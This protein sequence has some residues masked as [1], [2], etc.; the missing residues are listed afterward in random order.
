VSAHGTLG[1][2][3]FGAR[4]KLARSLAERGVAGTLKRAALWPARTSRRLSPDHIRRRREGR[5]FDRRHGVDT[6]KGLEAGWI[7]SL[8]GPSWR[9]AYGYDPITPTAFHRALAAI[10]LEP[11]RA[12]FVDF[13]AGKGRAMLLA[14]HYS[15]RRVLGVE[16]APG[17]HRVAAENLARYRP[18]ERVCQ[19]AEVV[20]G[21]ALAF[22]IP[23]DPAV[24]YFYDPFG[25]AVF[26]P[27][28]ERIRRSLL[29]RPRTAWIVYHDPR[30]GD[31]VERAGFRRVAG[32][33]GTVVYAWETGGA[34]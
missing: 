7:V 1:G 5:A 30:C 10:P 17:L 24:F 18:P 26:A 29:A 34:S 4:R 23:D 22:T 31:L 16:M 2:L 25:P 20:R 3:L 12:V 21:D 33:P 8:Q 9:H 6:A 13:G 32:A 27:L 19:D 15:F 14:T 11:D 28:L